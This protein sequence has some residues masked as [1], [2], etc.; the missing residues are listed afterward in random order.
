MIFNK[1]PGGGKKIKDATALPSDVRQG[2]VF[3]NN[4]GRSI[5]TKGEVELYSHKFLKGVYEKRSELYS[6]NEFYYIN[7]TFITSRADYL[8]WGAKA[9]C[10]GE[11]GDTKIDREIKCILPNPIKFK[12]LHKVIIRGEDDYGNPRDL[13]VNFSFIEEIIEKYYHFEFRSEL[14]HSS[15]SGTGY[16]VFEMNTENIVSIS[17]A[18]RQ[19]SYNA[20]EKDVTVELYYLYD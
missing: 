18:N 7:K 17:L 9:A 19:G 10:I 13:E 16:L 8:S 6:S 14:W 3:Y 12:N 4:N 1:I 15:N 11:G 2:K 20:I 5:G